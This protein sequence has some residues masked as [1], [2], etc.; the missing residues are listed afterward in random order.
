MP[1]ISQGGDHI[2]RVCYT[3]HVSVNTR[4]SK[5]G[6]ENL[7]ESLEGGQVDTCQHGFV[8][9]IILGWI[10]R[11]HEVTRI[12]GMHVLKQ[13]LDVTCIGMHAEIHSVDL[14][15]TILSSL[16]YQFCSRR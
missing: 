12:L 1:P 16:H 14:C 10:S 9:S 11:P 8:H 3:S 4:Y 15:K 13:C 7:P 2:E 5:M 6:S